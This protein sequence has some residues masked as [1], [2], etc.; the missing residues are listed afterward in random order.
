MQ[1]V[2]ESFLKKGQ[3]IQRSSRNYP[4]NKANIFSNYTLLCY[5]ED[6]KEN[7][8][9]LN[10][11]KPK[12]FWYC[13]VCRTNIDLWSSHGQEVFEVHSKKKRSFWISIP[14]QLGKLHLLMK[15]VWYDW[16]LQN[17]YWME[18]VCWYL[19]LNK[20]I[21]FFISI[22]SFLLLMFWPLLKSCCSM[23]TS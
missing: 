3:W 17:S 14:Q 22:S 6:L 20:S 5:F 8:H 2:L 13:I 11:L 4:L 18:L 12:Y 23:G 9:G 16:M 21:W 10:I 7:S 1:L 15:I 19:F